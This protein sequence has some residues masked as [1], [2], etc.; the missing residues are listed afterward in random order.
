MLVMRRL[1][2]GQFLMSHSH[3]AVAGCGKVGQPH[4]LGGGGG[5]GVRWRESRDEGERKVTVV[6]DIILP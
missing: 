1:I 4:H 6:L 3:A 5:G 2:T